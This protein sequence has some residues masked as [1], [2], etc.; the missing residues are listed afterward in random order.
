MSLSTN[1][2]WEWSV[3]NNLAY[4][5]LGGHTLVSKIKPCMSKYEQ[6]YSVKLRMAQRIASSS[7][8]WSTCDLVTIIRDMFNEC[9]HLILQTISCMLLWLLVVNFMTVYDDEFYSDIIIFSLIT[10][11]LVIPLLLLSIFDIFITLPSF[12]LSSY[13]IIL[14]HKKL[15]YFILYSVSDRLITWLL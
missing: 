9:L 8:S 3:N 13:E 6:V 11:Y 12:N 14:T 15:L 10:P 7:N 4:V 5:Q 1:Y 2:G